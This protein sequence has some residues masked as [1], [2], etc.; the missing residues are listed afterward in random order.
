MV[1]LKEA[2]NRVLASVQNQGSTPTSA[3]RSTSTDTAEGPRTSG[4]SVRDD[5]IP[6]NGEQRRAVARQAALA[7]QSEEERARKQAEHDE[8]CRQLQEQATQRTRAELFERSG[9][10]LRH[11][12]KVRSLREREAR[13]GPW[14]DAYRR[15]EGRLGNGFLISLLGSR[16]TGKTQLGVHLIHSFYG[17]YTDPPGNGLSNYFSPPAQYVKALDLFRRIRDCFSSN[18]EKESDVVGKLVRCKL[19]VIDEAHERGHTDFENRTLTNIIDARYDAMVDTLLI[20]NDTVDDFSK[21]VGPSII[22]RLNETGE[23]IECNWKS[24]R[25]A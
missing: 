16:G 2:V 3:K 4:P 20:S 19:L 25:D 9:V 11:R 22:S 13:E 23:V 10:P 6:W 17:R 14:L 5:D 15:L 12:Q 21:N 18:G 1:E 8:K 24:F 7:C